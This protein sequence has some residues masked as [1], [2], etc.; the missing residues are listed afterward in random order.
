MDTSYAL[1]CAL[2]AVWVQQ[3]SLLTKS[4]K[5]T[6][7]VHDSMKRVMKLHVVQR[8]FPCRIQSLDLLNLYSF[9]AAS[10][11]SVM[12]MTAS[13]SRVCPTSCKQVGAFFHT[14]GSS[15]EN[16]QDTFCTKDD[17]D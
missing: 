14:T 6:I 15:D 9:K 17:G 10:T 7:I 12:P 16:S 5:D 13:S 11:I 4:V 3:Q 1:V 2:V 8:A